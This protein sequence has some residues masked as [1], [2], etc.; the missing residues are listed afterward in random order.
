MARTDMPAAIAEVFITNQLER[1]PPPRPITFGKSSLQDLAGLMANHHSDVLPRLIQ[2]A[3]EIC[4]A[5]SAGVSVLDG[6]VFRWLALQGKLAVFEGAT[7]PRDHS[8]CGVCLDNRNA[9]LME[10]PERVYEWIRE[11]N[12]T[13][14]EVFSFRFMWAQGPR[15]PLGRREGRP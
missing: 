12:I 13:V 3:P 9:I 14:P 8:P 10:R 6:T 2:L 5:D 1:R 15:H 7:T 4:D 11:A